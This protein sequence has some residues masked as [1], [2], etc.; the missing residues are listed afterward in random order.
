MQFH[1]SSFAR[2]FRFI[3]LFLSR[4]SFPFFESDS[5]DRWRVDSMV[6]LNNIGSTKSCLPR[7]L[8]P[9][10]KQ[11]RANQTSTSPCVQNMNKGI[12]CQEEGDAGKR[13]FFPRR[14]CGRC[15][16][17]M[18][19]TTVLLFRLPQTRILA[20]HACGTRS[21]LGSDGLTA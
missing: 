18:S 8:W 2:S 21:G 19:H 9:M 3:N 7:E 13:L 4:N 12:R 17:V 15:F 16:A 5:G 14:F 6:P 20:C 10:R 11:E 1:N